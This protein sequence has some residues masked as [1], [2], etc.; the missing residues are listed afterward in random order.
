MSQLS[1]KQVP[2]Y[3]YAATHATSLRIEPAHGAIG[4]A[5]IWCYGMRGTELAYGAMR[6]A[7]L[8]YGTVLWG[9]VA[10]ALNAVP[11]ARDSRALYAAA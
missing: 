2:A 10:Q 7:V 11:L 8:S 5:S 6:K 9:Q 4:T 1:L 3:A